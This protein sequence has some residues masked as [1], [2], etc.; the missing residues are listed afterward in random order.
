VLQKRNTINNIKSNIYV[1]KFV[2]FWIFLS[3]LEAVNVGKIILGDENMLKLRRI[4]VTY[5][6][7]PGYA[8]KSSMIYVMKLMSPMRFS[9]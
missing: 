3:L 7:I 4:N 1:Y 8:E 6:T 2:N 5:R 9:A